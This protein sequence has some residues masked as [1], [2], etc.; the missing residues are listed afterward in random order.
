MFFTLSTSFSTKTNVEIPLK[1]VE[2]LVGNVENLLDCFFKKLQVVFFYILRI[3]S[4]QKKQGGH[5]KFV[6]LSIES[7]L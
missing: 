6:L 3:S 2:N 7:Y 1:A 5:N 4:R